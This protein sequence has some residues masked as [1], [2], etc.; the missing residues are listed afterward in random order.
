VVLVTLPTGE[1]TLSFRKN[2]DFVAFTWRMVDSVHVQDSEVV[3]VGYWQCVIHVLT[4]Y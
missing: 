2:D 4:Y 3:F 1:K